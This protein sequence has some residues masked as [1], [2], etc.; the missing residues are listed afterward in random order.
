M[1]GPQDP[2]QARN[3]EECIVSSPKIHSTA[4]LTMWLDRADPEMMQ[5]THKCMLHPWCYK[6][7]QMGKS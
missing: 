1:P 7:G 2:E 3:E 5:Q 4:P 6:P